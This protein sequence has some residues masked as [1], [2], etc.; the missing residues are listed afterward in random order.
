MIVLGDSELIY[1]R[2]RSSEKQSDCADQRESESARESARARE[3]ER[4]SSSLL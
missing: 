2:T 3:R 1:Y 4:E